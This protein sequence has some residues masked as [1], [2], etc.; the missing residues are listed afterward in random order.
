MSMA[1]PGMTH[2]SKCYSPLSMTEIGICKSCENKEKREA[3][4][5]KQELKDK[6]LKNTIR[7]EATDI[8]KEF[9]SVMAESKK[10]DKE[11]EDKTSIIVV[12]REKP[13]DMTYSDWYADIGYRVIK[14]YL[15]G[16]KQVKIRFGEGE[17][18]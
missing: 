12:S 1:F 10:I 13:E 9:V 8:M 6:E 15:G 18:I 14:E 2:C 5:H 17:V 16:N 7:K 11:L 3:E 4:K